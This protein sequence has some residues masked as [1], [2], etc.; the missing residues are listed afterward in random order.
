MLF[1]R[2]WRNQTEVKRFPMIFISFCD[3][4]RLLNGMEIPLLTQCFRF[5]DV[6][7]FPGPS[8]LQTSSARMQAECRQ[9]VSTHASAAALSPA[10]LSPPALS[11]PTRSIPAL[12]PPALGLPARTRDSQSVWTCV[13]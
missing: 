1:R 8:C 9:N 10:A 6:R 2:H 11:P 4:C 12:S 5:V 3:L 13:R 7:V